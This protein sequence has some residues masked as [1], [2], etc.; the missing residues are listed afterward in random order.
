MNCVNIN[1][2]PK[3]MRPNETGFFGE[4]GG[5][6]G[7]PVLAVEMEKI[8]AAFYDIIDDAHIYN[9]ALTAE[10]VKQLYN[11]GAVSFN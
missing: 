9:Y 6:V 8:K 1:D 2:L 11:G 4:Y 3:M 10:Q 5:P 7:H